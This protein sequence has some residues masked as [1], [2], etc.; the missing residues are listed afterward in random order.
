MRLL[1]VLAAGC[2]YAQTGANILLVVN[3]KDAASKEIAEYYRPRR[4]VPVKNVCTL[5]TTS[6]EEIDWNTYEQQ[7]ERP[8]ADCLRRNG[9][10]EKTLYIVTTLG[11]PLK[12]K[13]AGSGMTTEDASVDSELT[14]LYGKLKGQKYERS[15]FVS[16]PLYQR[17]D[18]PFSHP[19][20]PIYLV[21]RLAAY[22]VAEVKAMIDRSL[23]ARN[24]GKFVIDLSAPDDAEGNNWLRTAAILLPANRVYLEES[25][26][27][28][29]MQRDV[30][31]YASWGSNDPNRKLRDLGFVWLPGAIAAEYVSTSGRT[32]KRPP[33][34]WSYTTWSDHARHWAGSPQSLAADLIHQGATGAYG[35][36]YEPFLGLCARPDYLLPAYYQGRNL[37]ESYYISLPGLSWMAVVIGDPLCQIGKP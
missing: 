21:T 37:A 3:D 16:N 13:G 28:A 31:G 9:L 12:V 5:A 26:R 24:R 35:N 11:V 1:L 32:F 2:L 8:I 20:F 22:D 33:E 19:R 36:V 18:E 17:R 6:D 27:I 29:M 7:V 25:K 14:L 4:S 23:A 30:I 15:G 10:A 34:S